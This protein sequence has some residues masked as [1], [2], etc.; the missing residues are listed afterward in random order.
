MAA[1]DRTVE[2]AKRQ[3]PRAF[4]IG[5][6]LPYSGGVDPRRL[7]E[8]LDNLEE[9]AFAN[10]VGS[11]IPAGTEDV[12]NLEGSFTE[13]FGELG[14]EAI[15]FYVSFH[16]PTPDGLWGI[17]YFDHRVRQ[18]AEIVRHEFHLKH[19]EAA[20]LA[21]GIVRA[22]ELFHFRFDVYALYNELIL[23]KPLYNE[24]SQCVYRAVYC[25]ADCFEEALANRCGPQ[26]FH[27]AVFNAM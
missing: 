24:Y 16:K 2:L 10:A 22:H 8:R 14:S 18:F 23:Q 6:G 12:R 1:F 20:R 17:F 27:P 13:S 25:T 7:P 9:G 3:L 21:I 11:T 5:G 19:V 26:K 4:T 15:A